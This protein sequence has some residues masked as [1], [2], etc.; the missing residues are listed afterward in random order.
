MFPNAVSYNGAPTLSAPRL[1]AILD[2]TPSP[3]YAPVAARHAKTATR[4]FHTSAYQTTKRMTEQAKRSITSGFPL[5]TRGETVRPWIPG[6]STPEGI[7]ISTSL[8]LAVSGAGGGGEAIVKLAQHTAMGVM[9]A[10]SV[11]FPSAALLLAGGQR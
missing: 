5:S 11:G 6:L 3:R 10:V 8:A 7:L 2:H 4:P 9:V 1:A